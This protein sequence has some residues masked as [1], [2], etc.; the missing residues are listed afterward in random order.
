MARA[1]K[2]VIASK[3]KRGRRR[4]IATPEADEPESEVT[5]MIEAPEP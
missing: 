1:A 3:G 5:R 4:K 2:D